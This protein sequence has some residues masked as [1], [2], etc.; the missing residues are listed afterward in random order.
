MVENCSGYDYHG[1][2]AINMSKVDSRYESTDVDFQDLIDAVHAKGMKIILDVVFNHT[3]NFGE[4]N[5]CPMFTKKEIFL[6]LIA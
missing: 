5:L 4:E 6:L 1:Y 3:G 2:H